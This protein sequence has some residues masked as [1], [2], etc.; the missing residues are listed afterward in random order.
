MTDRVQD[1]QKSLTWLGR[2]GSAGA[3]FGLVAVLLLAPGRAAA[4]LLGPVNDYFTNAI[5]LVGGSGSTNGSTIGATREAGE[6]FH[7]GFTTGHSVW[8]QWTAPT[9]GVVTFDT[10]G[11]YA[12]SY[13]FD[14]ILAAYLNL[15]PRPPAVNNLG[16]VAENDDYYYS[17]AYSY[18][19]YYYTYYGLDSLITF[20]ALSG[21]TYYIAVDGF[22]DLSGPF[23]LHWSMPNSLTNLPL[24]ALDTNQIAFGALA[25]SVA[26]NTPGYATINVLYGGG[27]AGAVTVDYATSDNDAVAGVDYVPRSGTLTFAPGQTNINVLVPII[28]NAFPNSNRTF[29]VLLSNPTGGAVLGIASNAT[30]TILD[31]ETVPSPL[32]AGQFQFSAATY[33]ATQYETYNGGSHPGWLSAPGALITVTRT[34][35]STGRVMVDFSATNVFISTNIFGTNNLTNFFAIR[36]AVPGLDYIPTNGTLVFDDFQMSTNFVVPIYSAAASTLSYGQ[37]QVQLVLSNPRPWTDTN[38]PSL[39]EDPTLIQPTLNTNGDSAILNIVSAS[40]PGYFS[41]ER[42]H[43]R[44]DEAN[45]GNGIW[46]FYGGVG[47]VSVG[48]AWSW[49][50]PPP[51]DAGSDYARVG[52][53]VADFSQIVNFP[54]NSS[55]VYVPFT[56]LDDSQVEFNEDFFPYIYQLNS[57]PPVNPLAYFCNYTILF[58]EQPAGAADRE[59]NPDNVISTSPPANLTPGAN[60]EVRAVAVQPDGKTVL[61]GDFTAVNTVQRNYLARMNFDGSLDRSFDPGTGADGF[62]Q[63]VTL[64]GTNSL[65]AGKILISGGFTSYNNVLRNSIARVRSDGSLDPTF[66]PGN[67]A[68]GPIRFVFLRTDDKILI[69]GDFLYY[70]DVW[71]N[72]VA[73]LNPDGTLDQTFQPNLTLDGALWAVTPQDPADPLSSVYIGGS[74]TVLNGQFYGGVARLDFNG[75]LDPGFNPG[76]GADGPVYSILIEPNGRVLIGGGFTNVDLIPRGGVARLNPDGSLD[77]TFQPGSGVEG[78]VYCMTLNPNNQPMLGGRFS[79][80]NGTR[81]MGLALVKDDG[82]LDT[83]FLDTAYNQFAGLIKECSYDADHFVNSISFQPD[84]NVMIGGS[85]TNLGGNPSSRAPLRNSYTRYTRDTRS[86]RF[87]IAR[88]I[89]TWGVSGTNSNPTQAPGNAEFTFDSYTVDKNG[90]RLLVTMDRV[91]GSLGTLGVIASTEDRTAVG[92]R[93]YVP[94]QTAQY[95]PEGAGG[96]RSQ[97]YTGLEYFTVPILDNAFQN[98]NLTVNLYAANPFGSLNLGGEYVPL[99]GALGV[100]QATMTISAHDFNHGTLVFGQPTFATNENAGYATITVVRTNGLDGTVTVDY[101]T[102]N[103]SGRAGVDYYSTAGTLTFPSQQGTNTFKIR[104][105]NNSTV[106]FDRTVLLVLTNA[107]GG[108]ILPGGLPT[109]TA[110]TTLTIID[111]DFAP[112]RVNFSA[113]TFTA[114]EADGT[115]SITVT[116]TGGSTG[117]L[118][119]SYAVT[120]GTAVNGADYGAVSGSLYWADKD[121]ATKTFQVPL[122]HNG[123]VTGDLM[124]NLVLSGP[125]RAGALGQLSSATLVIQDADRYGEFFFSQSSYLADENGTN[126]LITV[127]RRHG[128]AGPVS[129]DFSTFPGTAIP[130]TDYYPTNGTLVFQSNVMAQVFGVGLSNNT[131]A[132]GNR[133][134]GLQLANVNPASGVLTNPSTAILTIIDDESFNIPAGSLDTAYSAQAQADDVVYSLALMPDGRLVAAGAFSFMNGIKRL[135]LA[136]LKESGSLDPTFNADAG[137]DGPIRA[138]AVQPDGKLVLGGLFGSVNGTNRQNIARLA[139]D[140]SLDASFNPSYGADNPVYAVA[141]QPEDDKIL[142]GGLFSKYA[143]VSSPGIARLNTNGTLDLSFA[144]GSGANGAVY[145]LALQT[146]GKVLIGGDFTQFNGQPAVRLV[147]LNR[148]G[149]RDTSFSVGSGFDAA[150]RAL[151]VQPD[152]RLVVGGSFT[153]INGTNFNRLVRLRLDGSVDGSFLHQAGGAAL[154]GGDGA[155]YVLAAQADGRILVGGDFTRFNGVTRGRLTRLTVDG[156]TDPSINF[157]DGANDFVYAIAVQQDRNILIGGGFTAYDGTSRQHLAR[158][159]GGS[160][161]GA[162]SLEFDPA[163]TEVSETT[164]AVTV[165][166]KRVGGTTGQV[167]ARVYTQDGSALAGLDYLGLTNTSVFPEGETRGTVQVAISNRFNFG[168]DLYF[169]LEMS[170]F[171]GGAAPGPQSEA[172]VRILASGST[173][174]FASASYSVNEND[175]SGHATIGVVRSGATNDTVTIAVATST[176]GST[177]GLGIRYQSASNV[178]TFL[179]GQT[180]Q[181]FQVPV[182]N[183][184]NIEGNQTVRLVLSNATPAALVRLGVTNADLSIVDDDNKVPGQIVFS[185]PLYSS[186]RAAADAPITVLRTNGSSGLTSVHFTTLPGG[187]GLAGLNYVPTNGTF[188]FADG[189]TVKTFHIPLPNNTNSGW[190]GNRTVYLQLSTPTGGATLGVPN[191]AILTIQDYQPAPAFL[192]FITNNFVI[193]GKQAYASITVGRT[194]NPATRVSVGFTVTNGT[195]L[196]WGDFIPTNGTISFEANELFKSFVVT[197]VNTNQTVQPDLTVLL[198]LTNALP[199]GSSVADSNVV[200]IGTPSNAVLTIQNDNTG[201]L[202]DRTNFVTSSWSGQAV[203]TVDRIGVTNRPVTVDYYTGTNGTA[204]PGL[205][206]LATNG[207]LLFASGVTQLSLTVPVLRNSLLRPDLIVPLV[208]TNVVGD[209][210]LVRPT[211]TLTITNANQNPGSLV[212]SAVSYQVA[213]NGTNAVVTLLRTNGAFGVVSVDYVTLE[214]TAKASLHYVPASGTLVFLPGQTTRTIV[215]P[216]ID[217]KRVEGNRYFWLS[218]NNPVGGADLPGATTAKVTIVEDDSSAGALD[219][220]FNPGSGADSAVLSV[221]V[222]PDGKIVAGGSFAMMNGV[223]HNYLARLQA[224]GSLDAGFLP[225]TSYTNGMAVLVTNYINIYPY[226]SVASNYLMLTN[227]V[228]AGPGAAVLAVACLTNNTVVF[229][230]VFTNYVTVHGTNF[231]STNCN[232]LG[233]ALSSGDLDPAFARANDLNASVWAISVQPRNKLYLGGGFSKPKAGIAR[234]MATGAVDTGFDPGVGADGLVYAAA[235][236]LPSGVV[237]GGEFSNV[238]GVART[239]VARLYNSGTL[240]LTFNPPAITDGVVY[241]LLVQPD[242]QVVIAGDFTAVGTNHCGRII[243]L[244]TDGTVDPTFGVGSGAGA[245]NNIYALALQPDGK[246]LIA[247]DFLNYNGQQRVRLARLMPDGSL[248]ASFQVGYGPNNTVFTLAPQ[249][250]GNIVIGGSFTQVFGNDRAGVARVFGDNFLVPTKLGLPAPGLY[251]VSLTFTVQPNATYVLSASPD[252]R[253]WTDLTTNVAAGVVNTYT[254]TNAPAPSY[255]F[256]RLRV[257]AP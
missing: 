158:L 215:V 181:F 254:D 148:D 213:E 68:D 149:T 118:R 77:P 88:L 55:G 219:P 180:L 143:G 115:A 146:D 128:S 212:F 124:A 206:Y 49:A 12:L 198:A 199:T 255:Q 217:D 105:I 177:A 92:N 157:G 5:V 121:S 247:G 257:V 141:L 2:L 107:T 236:Y 152:G 101:S 111:D 190:Q 189:E 30:V 98:G 64:Y 135:H 214:A 53:D 220:T 100:S 106:D 8:F 216:I 82:T 17:Y 22:A 99:G 123:R 109:S 191:N 70:N 108:A 178:L 156:A 150:V 175:P 252:L 229:G 13:N 61:G 238:G 126:L 67:G 39:S 248:D 14:T 242:G 28:D 83:S 134:I 225:P 72:G 73:L 209:A 154:V 104:L 237:L 250:D 35:G 192:S 162:G 113:D 160:M 246:I 167:Q 38:N 31:N 80:Y 136:R 204:V 155:V 195:A 235:G 182:I 58:D 161:A 131:I 76:A 119:V 16:L 46:I 179:P 164:P 171:G 89:G 7:L 169:N 87:N 221:A 129:V 69:V 253:H 45:T 103:G 256:Y 59:W 144:V 228:P 63:T 4:Q 40:V 112:G 56:F 174:G 33:R 54:Q 62:V 19:Y 81:R 234:F 117:D 120:D 168:D 102:A 224:D 71:R 132:D 34:N 66:T 9:N 245:D 205:D 200:I 244:G 74:F 26:E 231:W 210:I 15:P 85:F 203:V 186:S 194:Y 241:A 170:D 27:L 151:L 50:S 197:L 51:L 114:N 42:A 163:L 142:V 243:R 25:F 21:T 222:Q 65:N 86:P 202:F 208:L 165:G 239:R 47:P 188:Y 11:T 24:P 90:V 137:P 93:D 75:N 32:H 43:Y 232:H 133:T 23:V 3:A 166:I 84:G 60:Y 130:G 193:I 211:A 201:L 138:I 110:V 249:P 44:N 147:R 226:Y 251:G 187:T 173:V 183:D 122:L 36:P 196:P 218:L 79:S 176:L 153:N 116:R 78:T 94:E 230:G 52:V 139:I 97:G 6:P 140:G 91:S 37:A 125:S 18:Y 41:I 172:F 223:P 240:D 207:T 233:R 227:L 184:T 10:L 48:L 57:Q 20:T 145:A 159:Y 1:R 127:S 95:W 29:F 185:A 96:M